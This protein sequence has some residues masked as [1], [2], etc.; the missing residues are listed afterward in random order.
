MTT[1]PSLW[2]L[3]FCLTTPTTVPAQSPSLSSE[4]V[5]PQ[6]CVPLNLDNLR[7]ITSSKDLVAMATGSPTA[8]TQVNI[9]DYKILCEGVVRGC[10]GPAYLLVVEYQCLGEWCGMIEG[11]G[12]REVRVFQACC[13]SPPWY[14][15]TTD[16]SQLLATTQGQC[17]GM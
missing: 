2:V 12:G 5:P 17:L 16:T 14:N 9:T 15:L 8:D 11:E 13:S 4:S 3:L 1:I 7:N 10:V 6:S